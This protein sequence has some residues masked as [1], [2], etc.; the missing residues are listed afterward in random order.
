MQEVPH[1]PKANRPTDIV[2]KVDCSTITL[3]DC[4]IRRGKWYEMQDLPF[5]PGSDFVGTVHEIGSEASKCST[6]QVGDRVVAFSSFG[7]N[8]K[9]ITVEYCSL[10]RVPPGVKSEV[11]LSLCSTYVPAREALDLGRKMN[12]PFT[13][14]NILVIGGNGPN[15]L[16]AIELALLEGAKVFATADE[17]HHQHLTKLGVTC[18]PINP[19]EWL[20]ALKGKMD[21]VLDSVCL[22][23][24]KSSS[25]AL[26]SSGIIVCTGMSFVYTQGE[27]SG[28]LMKDVRDMTAM[29][30]KTKVKFLWGNAKYYD[31]VERFASAPNEY[32]VSY[33]L[34]NVDLFLIHCSFHNTLVFSPLKSNIFGIC[35]T[36]HPRVQSR[37][38][39]LLVHH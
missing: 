33:S 38:W 1:I 15:G 20:P 34:Q 25:L 9:Y 39:C 31:R 10:I 6:F 5:I 23:G 12:T 26:N 7:G 8:A 19:T 24:F 2:V 30:I 17:R 21:V 14:A 27:V 37:H 28:L 29:Y 3:Q 32:A 11:A 16:A 13:G 4:M 22:D 18:Y 35:V 36:L